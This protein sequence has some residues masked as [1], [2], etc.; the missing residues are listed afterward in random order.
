MLKNIK[1]TMTP[2]SFKANSAQTELG[3][4][5]PQLVS[6]FSVKL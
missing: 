3:T 5:Q 4:A 1:G 6:R 2:Q